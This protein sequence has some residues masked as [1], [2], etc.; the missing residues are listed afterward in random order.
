MYYYYGPNGGEYV[1]PNRDF[2]FSRAAFLGT[3]DVFTKE[4][5]TQKTKKTSKYSVLSTIVRRSL[6]DLCF[7]IHAY[8][9]DLEQLSL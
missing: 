4:A 6:A 8:R 2:A 7:Y 1:T 5:E 3:N 9:P